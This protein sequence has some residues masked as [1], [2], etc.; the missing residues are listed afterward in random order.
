MITPVEFK[1]LTFE[2]KTEISA[3][4]QLICQYETTGS[5]QDEMK[6]ALRRFHF[7]DF[8]VIAA[9]NQTYGRGRQGRHWHSLPGKNALF[10]VY[11][12]GI[13]DTV[14]MEMLYQSVALAV[15]KS[16]LRNHCRKAVIKYPNDVLVDGKKIAGIL[17]ET[18]I[19][20]NRIHDVIAGIGINVNQQ[21]FPPSLNATSIIRETGRKTDIN[22][23][24]IDTVKE[25][26]N[27]IQSNQSEILEAFT[28][29]WHR[30]GKKKGITVYGKPVEGR[31]KHLKNG[32]IYLETGNGMKTFLAEA[33][34]PWL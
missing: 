6:K 8:A 1:Y 13:F 21:N 25:I 5:T 34:E 31:I 14:N 7:P 29:F 9:Q 15:V 3:D 33:C 12:P 4:Y 22:R 10:S 2:K 19:R 27:L 30:Q 11:I 17:I 28:Y 32:L 23:I 18:N 16:L 24:I 20:Q 26:K